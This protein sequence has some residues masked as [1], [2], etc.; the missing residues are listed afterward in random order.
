M[1]VHTRANTRV[2]TRT[3]THARTHARALSLARS[4][5]LPPSLK[6]PH[7]SLNSISTHHRS[8]PC[9]KKHPHTPTRRGLR[10]LDGGKGSVSEHNFF[11]SFFS[12]RTGD[13]ERGLSLSVSLLLEWVLLDWVSLECFLLIEYFLLLK[14]ILTRMYA[15]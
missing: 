1:C 2:C 10:A 15:M 13:D 11:L 14:C 7:Q 12:T 8:P 4:L 5:S 3:R 6:P 9:G